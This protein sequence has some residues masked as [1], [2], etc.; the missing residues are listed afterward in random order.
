MFGVLAVLVCPPVDEV[1]AV[2]PDVGEGVVTGGAGEPCRL[3]GA[4]R[5]PG[6]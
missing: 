3:P 5:C 6:T 2:L 1:R 4:R